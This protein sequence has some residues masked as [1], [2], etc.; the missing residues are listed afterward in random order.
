MGSPYG[1]QFVKVPYEL[2]EMRFKRQ[3]PEGSQDVR[4][5]IK[6][7]PTVYPIPFEDF[8]TRLSGQI[9]SVLLGLVYATISTTTNLSGYSSRGSTRTLT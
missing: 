9:F 8:F 1:T 3:G 7:S 4:K 5:I 6:S 2:R